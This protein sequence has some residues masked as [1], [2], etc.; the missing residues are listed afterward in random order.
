MFP[1]I[2]ILICAVVAILI[3]ILVFHNPMSEP[4]TPQEQAASKIEL[5]QKQTKKSILYNEAQEITTPTHY[6]NTEPFLLKD[7]IGKKV[8][9]VEFWT[10][11]CINCQHVV[12]HIEELHQ[13]YKDQGLLIVGIHTPEFPFEHKIENVEQA[14]KD[15]GI[16]YPVVMDNDYSTWRA[17]KNNYW[18]R[19]YLIDK[20]GYI[21]FNHIGE[22]AYDITENHIKD[23]LEEL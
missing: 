22:G 20:D 1:K 19:L 11:S 15:Q 7:Y 21:R 16:T 4:L 5:P 13:R 2:F 17:Y 12:P 3:L 18:P 10:Y 23:L 14:V 9:L 8:I 6:I